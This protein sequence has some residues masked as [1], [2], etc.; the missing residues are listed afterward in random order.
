MLTR[1]NSVEVAARNAR[2]L[3]RLVNSL[4]DFAQIDS[5]GLHRAYAPTD[6][7]SAT[8]GIS[9]SFRSA[10]ERAGLRLRVECTPLGDPVYV[11]VEA[12]EKIVLN[13]LSNAFKFTFSGEIAVGLQ[14]VDGMAELTVSDTGV[15]IPE[16]ELPRL[17][18][19][20]RR[21]R[22]TSARSHDGVGIGLA[23]VQELVGLHGGDVEVESRLGTGTTVRVRIPFGRAHLPPPQVVAEGIAAIPAA[24]V[25][26]AIEDAERWHPDRRAS[27]RPRR[28]RRGPT[29]HTSWSPTT[30]PTCAATSSDCSARGGA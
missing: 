23:L 4:I 8:S 9:S 28:S 10:V 15:G 21:V 26:G 16:Q 29:C 5:G 24:L 6:L 30:T 27:P 18:E 12:W 13:L 1:G 19:R 25:E 22:G 2:R 14:R 3:A 7:A 17:F 20:F 11:D